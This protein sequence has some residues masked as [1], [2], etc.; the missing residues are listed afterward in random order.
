MTR[1]RNPAPPQRQGRPGRAPSLTVE[2]V[3][4]ALEGVPGVRGDAAERAR[5][6]LDGKRRDYPEWWSSQGIKR[7][8]QLAQVVG[9]THGS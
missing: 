9:V 8:A 1:R 5:A 7:L 4:R 6:Y 2:E 3:M